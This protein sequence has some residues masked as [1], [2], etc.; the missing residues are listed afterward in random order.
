MSENEYVLSLMAIV[1]GLAIT[2]MIASLYAL[3]SHRSI[4]RFDWLAMTAATLVAYTV[5]YGW[6]VTWA[7]F[8]GRT[9]HL[10]FWEFLLPL[11]NLAILVLAAYAALP[12]KMPEAGID[13]RERY[14]LNGVWIWRALLAVTLIAIGSLALKNVTGEAYGAGAAPW[15]FA[16][17]MFQAASYGVLSLTRSRRVHVALVPLLLFLLVAATFL[18]PV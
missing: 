4:V 18:Q 17:L 5:V 10:M 3:L 1:S 6:W 16:G 2:H 9:G 14:S 7:V 12:E 15:G 8:N 11:I 13:L